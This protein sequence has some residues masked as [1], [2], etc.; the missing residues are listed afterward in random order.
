VLAQITCH[1]CLAPSGKH[2][3]IVFVRNGSKGSACSVHLAH[4]RCC[5]DVTPTHA[6]PPAE[7]V[8][9]QSCKLIYTVQGYYLLVPSLLCAQPAICPACSVHC[10]S[11][12]LSVRC[13]VPLSCAVWLACRAGCQNTKLT[14]L[15]DGAPNFRQ[16]EGLPVYG[17]AI[18][19]VRGLRN[20]MDVLGAAQGQC[21]DTVVAHTRNSSRL[22]TLQVLL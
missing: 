10:L 1:A 4:S 15:L 11:S 22:Q 19:T 6:N 17:V 14:P 18:P 3:Y 16:V 7:S 8:E 9:R 20:V 12:E 2:G 21:A 13:A 5:S